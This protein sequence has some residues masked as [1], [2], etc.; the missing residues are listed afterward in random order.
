M[1]RERAQ[2]LLLRLTIDFQSGPDVMK[3]GGGMIYTECQAVATCKSPALATGIYC[4][5]SVSF[6][7]VLAY[8]PGF[9]ST[10]ID[11]LGPAS[12]MPTG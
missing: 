11:A 1:L 12:P 10:L 9:L 4:A 5:I 3:L 6:L 7:P 8:C 2:T